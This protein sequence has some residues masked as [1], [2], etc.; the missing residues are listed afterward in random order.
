M[1]KFWMK[2]FI[3]LGVIW[4]VNSLWVIGVI[5]KFVRVL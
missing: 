3:C 1:W 2:V 5:W 4:F